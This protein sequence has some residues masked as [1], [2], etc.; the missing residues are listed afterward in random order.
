MGETAKRE[1]F[2]D[3]V[4]GREGLEEMESLE[5]EADRLAAHPRYRRFFLVVDGFAGKDDTAGV[6]A[7]QPGKNAE[8]RGLPGARGP[9]EHD[10]LSTSHRQRD[11]G[12]HRN[13]F[14][15]ALTTAPH[16]LSL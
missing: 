9:D 15:A 14:A 13:R 10:Q 8:Q 3:V 1:H 7:E 4:F 2:G 5:H 12:Q 11:V 6:R 16:A